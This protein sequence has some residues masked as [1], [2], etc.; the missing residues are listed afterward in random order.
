MLTRS[1]SLK[2]GNTFLAVSSI[3]YFLDEILCYSRSCVFFTA[4]ACNFYRS[5]CLI[6]L[7]SPDSLKF[8]GD[9]AVSFLALGELMTYSSKF[10]GGPPTIIMDGV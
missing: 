10:D 1:G 7:N 4:P 5:S 6:E 2:S 3:S 8:G 9:L